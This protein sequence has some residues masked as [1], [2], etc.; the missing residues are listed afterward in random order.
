MAQLAVVV[1]ILAI[2]VGACDAAGASPSE[3]AEP[4]PVGDLAGTAWVVTAIGGT[5]V[6]LPEPPLIE[7]GSEGRIAGSTGCNSMMGTYAV[8]GASLSFGPLAT[9]KRACAAPNGEVE[10][11]LLEALASV[12]GWEVGGDGLLRLT[13]GTEVVL[14]PIAT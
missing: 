10:T 6:A 2:A 9:T 11:V 7:F 13:G 14:A 5:Q 4:T 8:D 12:T 3:S 1:A